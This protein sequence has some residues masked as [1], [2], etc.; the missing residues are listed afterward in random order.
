MFSKK[1]QYFAFNML[2]MIF[3]V[4]V[5][6]SM[7]ILL[8]CIEPKIYPVLNHFT[9]DEVAELDDKDGF[10]IKGTLDKNRSCTFKAITIYTKRDYDNKLIPVNYSFEKNNQIH[11]RAPV[12]QSWGPWTIHLPSDYKSANIFIYTTHECHPMYDTVSL[13]KEFEI[14]NT[15]NALV[16]RQ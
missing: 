7:M 4:F 3:G 9:I 10:T 2:Q 15:G 1:A 6:V 16:I 14:I 12:E 13:A 11:S 5:F 8:Q